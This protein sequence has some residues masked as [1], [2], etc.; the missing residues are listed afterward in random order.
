M[1]LENII[2]S[3]VSQRK[4]NTIGYHLFVEFKIR[5]RCTYLQTETDSHT[6]RSD[7]CLRSGR[8]GVGGVD[9]AFGVCRCNLLYRGQ[10]NNMVLLYIPQGT[11]WLKLSWKRVKNKKNVYMCLTESLCYTAEIGT[12]L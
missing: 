6:Q 12:T 11:F 10:I 9:G 8:R 1:D 4:T 7:L 5:H 2:L 3:E